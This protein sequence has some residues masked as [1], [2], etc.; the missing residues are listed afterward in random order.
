MISYNINIKK[1]KF[2]VSVLLLAAEFSGKCQGL[3]V[4]EA[5]LYKCDQF[6]S[7]NE[8][9]GCMIDDLARL[10]DIKDS[11]SVLSD[12]HFNSRLGGEVAMGDG[13]KKAP[14]A[15]AS[16]ASQ[17]DSHAGKFRFTPGEWYI[18]V[19]QMICLYYFTQCCCAFCINVLKKKKQAAAT[20]PD[21]EPMMMEEP[22]ADTMMEEAPEEMMMAEGEEM[23]AAE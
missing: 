4:P 14:P 16:L 3:G 20:I 6:E 12:P 1:M 5:Y 21:D 13:L 2:V 22:S 23:M 17:A 8:R 11:V 10:G 19:F 7:E 15:A 18:F 9:V